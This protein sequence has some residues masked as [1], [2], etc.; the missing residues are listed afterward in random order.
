M[1]ITKGWFTMKDNAKIAELQDMLRLQ[2]GLQNVS[3][4]INAA[5]SAKQI[6][7]ET[8]PLLIDL[9]HVEAAHIYI[10]DKHKKEMFTFI[11]YGDMTKDRKAFVNH[12]T[13]PGYVMS[14]AKMINISDF[15][16]PEQINRYPDLPLDAKGDNR[17]G[18]PV[19][20]ILAMPIFM[21]VIL[22]APLSLSIRKTRMNRLRIKNWRSCIISRKCWALPS[23]TTSRL[24]RKREN[25]NTAI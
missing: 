25:Q 10:N 7:M 9:F 3:N 2:K 21:A 22:W 4:S 24:I 13:I 15:S 5:K 14:M 12:Q 16:N 19:K 18:H 6:I 11:L 17:F 8:R 23:T 20:Q 1:R